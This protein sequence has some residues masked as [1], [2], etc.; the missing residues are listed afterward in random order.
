MDK[1]PTMENLGGPFLNG[2]H[3]VLDRGQ[4]LLEG[5]LGLP[6]SGTALG[7]P[8]SNGGILT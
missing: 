2:R 4:L 8:L 7:V 5:L 6:V 3:L 1:T